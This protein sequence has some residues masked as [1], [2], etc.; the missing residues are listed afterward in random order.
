[1]AEICGISDRQVR[2]CITALKSNGLLRS[3][4]RIGP[5][6]QTS[7]RYHL[8]VDTSVHPSLD[9]SVLPSHDTHVRGGRTPTSTNTKED[10]KEL[11]TLDFNAWW[12]VYPRKAGK[13]NAAKSYKKAVKEISHKRL[14]EITMR[15]T[16]TNTQTEMRFI[17]HAATW[18]NQ[19]R[20]ADEELNI[21]QTMNNLAG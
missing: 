15:F 10:T 7:N 18:L 1:M 2:R 13:F 19:K 12:K 17:P 8:S 4:A 3:E 16:V 5:R 21:I 9:T 20:Y 14:L 11:Y 6:G